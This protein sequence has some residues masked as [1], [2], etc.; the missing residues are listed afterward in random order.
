MGGSLAR[1]EP[2]ISIPRSA[3]ALPAPYCQ[4]VFFRRGE[5]PL[6]FKG[7]KGMSEENGI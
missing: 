7:D 4:A 6:D 2:T 1:L 3:T 5:M